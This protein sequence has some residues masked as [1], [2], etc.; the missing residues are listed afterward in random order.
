MKYILFILT[1]TNS[2][3]SYSQ[4]CEGVDCLANPKIIQNTN[5]TECFV[6]APVDSLFDNFQTD[7]SGVCGNDCIDICENSIESFSTPYSIGSQYNWS[8]IGGDI[9]EYFSFNS[10]VVIQWGNSTS[11][12]LLVEEIDSNG[13]SKSDFICIDLKST[14]E[15]QIQTLSGDTV[16]CV[17]TDIQFFGNNQNTTELTEQECYP[18]WIYEEFYWYF[19]S[20]QSQYSYSTHYFW[21]FGDGNTSNQAN[22]I[23]S[24][25]SS[26]AKTV[27]LIMFNNCQC[28]DTITMDLF[29]NSDIG[30]K[31][32]SCLGASCEGDTAL[33]CT[34]A[35]M[36]EWSIN[37]GFILNNTLNQECIKVVW[38][39][40]DNSLIDGEGT[41]IVSDGATSCGSG[42]TYFSVPILS[43]NPSIVGAELVCE[44][45]YEVY[46][47]ECIP[48]VEYNWSVIGGNIVGGLNTSEIKVSWGSQDNGQ[49]FLNLSSSTI[50][51]GISQTS[52]EVDILPTISINGVNLAC[53]D[54]TYTFFEDQFSNTIQWSVENGNILNSLNPVNNISSQIDVVFNQN[55]GPSS[56]IAIATQDGVFCQEMST[57]NVNI[58]ERPQSILAISGDSIICPGEAYIYTLSD[59]SPNDQ[60][61]TYNWLI[62]G[63]TANSNTGETVS[64]DWD[65]VGPYEINVYK[66]LNSNPY[67]YSDTFSLSVNASSITSPIVSGTTTSCTNS[68]STFQ[69]ET[70]YPTG[71][72]ISWNL[73]NSSY[74][75]IVG[76]QGSNVVEVEWGNNTG[77][78]DLNIGVDICGQTITS[79]L[80]IE[81]INE[82]VT[83]SLGDSILCSEE[84]VTFVPSSGAGEYY[85]LFGDGTSSTAQS[86]LKTYEDP[87]VYNVN[88]TF[89]DNINQCQ[90]TFNSTISIAG[91]NGQLFP[92][93]TSLFCASTEIN[94]PL[95]IVSSSTY[96]PSV[97]WFSNGVSLGNFSEYTVLST[98]PNH[99]GLGIY[100]A[101][102]SDENGCYNTLN[103]IVI[104]TVNCGNGGG[105]FGNDPNLLC[106]PLSNLPYTSSCNSDLGTNTFIFNSPDGSVV[107]WK[108]DNGPISSSATSSFT[109][110]EAGIHTVR[111]RSASCLIGVE[112]ITIPLVVDFTYSVVCNPLANNEIT[113]HFNDISSYLNGYGTAVYSW[114]FG[115]GN[116]S[117]NQN[118]THSYSSNG[119]FI[120]RLTVD[121]GG[122]SCDKIMVINHDGFFIDYSFVG[123][124]CENTPTLTFSSFN[125]I[126]PIS[127]WLWDFGDGSS[128]ARPSPRRTFSNPSNYATTLQVT[129]IF[130]C[131]AN[132]S[133]LITI[134][135]TPNINSISNIPPLCS[136]DSPI[137]LT[138]LIDYDV[139]NGETVQWTGQGVEYDIIT[140]VYYFNPL[141]AGGGLHQL[142][143]VVT[144]NNACFVEECINVDVICPEK[145]KVFG[146]TDFCL[147][148]D[149]E[150]YTYTTQNGMSNYQWHVNGA[151]TLAN[152]QNITFNSFTIENVV[153]LMVEFTDNNGCSSISE[154]FN[155]SVKPLPSAFTA[156]AVTN[157]C[158]EQSLTLSHN[159][160]E[161]NVT[162]Q[163]NTPEKHLQ[164]T[165]DIISQSNYDYYVLATNQFGCKRKSNSVS[166]HQAPNMCSVLSGCYCDSSIVN[167]NNT[168]LISGVSPYGFYNVEWLRN[169]AS[170]PNPVFSNNLLLDLSGPNYSNLVPGTFNLQVTDNYG[171]VYTSEDLYIET[172]CSPCDDALFS[173]IKDTICEG[174]LYSINGN[175]FNTSGVYT[176]SFMTPDGCDT[177]VELEL[178]VLPIDTV[179]I[180]HEA[181]DSFIWNNETYIES[182]SYTHI[183]TNSFGCSQTHELSLIIQ[184]SDSTFTSVT[185][186]TSYTWDNVTYNETGVYTN[187]YTNS[188]GCDSIHTLDLTIFPTSVSADQQ[189]HCDEFT[190]I[191]GI[192]YTE[193]N[194]TATY[195]LTN[196]FGC[197]SLVSLNLIINETDSLFE[198][199]VV[200]D[201]YT[202]MDG[203][204]YYDSEVL[205]YTST[206]SNGCDS[207][208]TLDLNVNFS[209]TSSSTATACWSYNWNGNTY[210]TSG[211]YVYE[212]INDA[213]CSETNTLNLTINDTLIF[214]TSAYMCGPYEWNGVTYYESGLYS[215]QTVDSNNCVNI[216]YL[217]FNLTV[218]DSLEI[219]GDTLIYIDDLSASYSILNAKQ[220]SNYFWS[221]ENGNGLIDATTLN[222]SE[223]DIEWVFNDDI[224]QLCVTEQDQYGCFGQEMCIDI[225]FKEGNSSIVDSPIVGFKIYPNPTEGVLNVVF[226]SSQAQNIEISV[227]DKLGKSIQSIKLNDYE[228]EYSKVID[229]SDKS[230][231]CIC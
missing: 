101:V 69:L 198:S 110:D 123:P 225:V 126:T 105:W 1:F 50:D 131:V 96:S 39:N 25:S 89:I 79:S 170:L 103:E 32:E 153:N 62:V 94:L 17:E 13:C 104:D 102:I 76:G 26:G 95:H 128:S 145:P 113:Y 80:S 119:T 162:Y 211:T 61:A 193:S 175:N 163:W 169:G 160:N 129:D 117:T 166:T 30:P 204:T 14:P 109:F 29:I 52:L 141:L 86:P 190:W 67:C 115:D 112:Q 196:S 71:S 40:N 108:L 37:G 157:N 132:N 188:N 231:G 138:S 56:I 43:S 177:T 46:S 27:T 146:E 135:S 34:D 70:N 88:L 195:V 223:V 172:N 91:I 74:G 118:P 42:Q 2:F 181:C 92:K 191:D 127:N 136:N 222:S 90:S 6:P 227:L 144:D 155:I 5:P 210:T 202:W 209:T 201:E 3:L 64:V 75:S 150:F 134:E 53:E 179:Y 159:G 183:E 221:I 47:Y 120:V 44:N 20:L 60:N 81:L 66:L 194:S 58:V 12:A 161:N 137:D 100:S 54:Q 139:T 192:T 186:C 121:Y 45:T 116:V 84:A 107:Q 124:Y 59:S 217:E 82:Q 197:D 16:F 167:N 173:S 168:I 147:P 208:I 15:A 106:P 18:D 149:F 38:D 33:Y 8:V 51:C 19:D 156:Y 174:D 185:S 226:E 83:F 111:A 98:P 87:G 187:L 203:Q 219:S 229:L 36:P 21:D 176:T 114:D 143:A 200:C 85:W 171:C 31:I 206:N 199:V 4:N 97:E 220:T 93:G 224:A 178:T 218:F 215:F 23:Y 35:T 228:G 151:P 9:I 77:F 24:Y 11:G 72:V 49:V 180:Y 140:Q 73:S 216:E 7:T 154:P 230:G 213:G 164:T 158:P 148:T 122:Y 214:E 68:I 142:C 212:S 125:N 205:T 10:G 130:G 133:Q 165:I 41:L 63:G 184:S 55:S 22:P 207:V 28:S 78:V 57:F 189:I 182:G 48:G 152:T 99:N 65:P